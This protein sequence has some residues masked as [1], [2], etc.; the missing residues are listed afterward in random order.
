MSKQVAIGFDHSHNNR[1]TIENNAFTDFI[2][3][4]FDSDFKLGKI[5][6]G[7]NKEKL[8]PYDLFIIG[9]PTLGPD[10]DSDEIDDLVNYVDNGGSILVVNDEGGDYKNKNNLSKLTE[11]FGIVFN[12]DQL[13]DNKYFSKNNSHPRIKD[14]RSHFITRNV[15]E[16]IHSNGCT[17]IIDKS[18][19]NDNLDVQAIAYS[20]ENTSWHRVFKEDAWID[21]S[22]QN[23]PII[24]VAHFGL[25]KVV[26]M[27]NLSLLS[28]LNPSYGIRAADNFKLIVNIISWLLNKATSKEQLIKPIYL[29]VPIE[30]DLYYW[31]KELLNDG[32]WNNIEEIIN[33]SLK[34]TKNSLK[35]QA[36]TKNST[37]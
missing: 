37:E 16:V 17:V 1:L 31:L 14:F 7:I 8:T 9:V 25:G 22:K 29:T 26:A 34:N 23:L 12:S 10:L 32:K 5:V 33:F 3:Y 6:A 18:V 28:S 20:S 13:F 30:Q 36:I 4:L 19:E 11:N 27:G 2:Q 15:S 35:T 21:E 24:G